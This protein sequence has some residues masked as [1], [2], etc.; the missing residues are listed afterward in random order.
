MTLTVQQPATRPQSEPGRL[1]TLSPARRPRPPTRRAELLRPYGTTSPHQTGPARSSGRPGPGVARH[2]QPPASASPARLRSQRLPGAASRRAE[3]EAVAAASAWTRRGQHI[4]PT[5][6]PRR[7]RAAPLHP[8]NQPSTSTSASST[9]SLWMPARAAGA[10][11]QIHPLVRRARPPR[12][13]GRSSPSSSTAGPLTRGQSVRFS[14][15]AQQQPLQRPPPTAP[16]RGALLRRVG[17]ESSTASLNQISVKR[18]S[19]L[20]ISHTKSRRRRVGT[21]TTATRVARSSRADTSHFTTS[22]QQLSLSHPPCRYQLHE[23]RRRL[24]PRRAVHQAAAAQPAGGASRPRVGPRPARAGSASSLSPCTFST[25]GAGMKMLGKRAPPPRA[26]LSFIVDARGR[27]RAIPGPQLAD[28]LIDTCIVPAS[29]RPSAARARR[30]PA[31]PVVTVDDALPGSNHQQVRRQRRER[32]A[33][34][35]TPARARHRRVTGASPG[36][37]STPT[38][39]A[40]PGTSRSARMLG[41]RRR[42]RFDIAAPSRPRPRPRPRRC[43][44]TSRRPHVLPVGL[45]RLQRLRRR[46]RSGP[47]R[48]WPPVDHRL[49]RPADGAGGRAAVDSVARPGQGRRRRGACSRPRVDRQPQGQGRRVASARARWSTPRQ[50]ARRSRFDLSR[51]QPRGGFSRSPPARAAAR[52]GRPVA[53]GGQIHRG[54]G[55]AAGQRAVAARRPRRAPPA[56][57]DGRRVSPSSST[58]PSGSTQTTSHGLPTLTHSDPPV[59][60]QIPLQR[61]RRAPRRTQRP[62]LL[63]QVVTAGTASGRHSTHDGVPARRSVKL[64]LACHHHPRPVQAVPCRVPDEDEP[65]LSLQPHGRCHRS[66]ARSPPLLEGRR[67]SVSAQ[68]SMLCSMR[69]VTLPARA[70]PRRAPRPGVGTYSARRRSPSTI[71]RAGK[72]APVHQAQCSWAGGARRM[73]L[74]IHHSH[75]DHPRTPSVSSEPIVPVALRTQPDGASPGT[76]VRPANILLEK[77]TTTTAQPAGSTTMTIFQ[78]RV[79]ASAHIRGRPPPRPAACRPSICV[80]VTERLPPTAGPRTP[81]PPRAGRGVE[82]VALLTL[83]EVAHAQRALVQVLAGRR[84][85]RTG[86]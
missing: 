10:A 22:P 21:T 17:I 67:P 83:A 51:L 69:C 32:L 56:F 50:Q 52:R 76:E 24:R 73:H 38:S 29:T 85:C 75:Q 11:R 40:G 44:P 39:P 33:R 84:R 54:P 72:V 28:Q 82:R 63:D 58:S 9:G 25:S 20:R 42:G 3:L 23:V 70:R 12:P 49:R 79:P 45:S 36:R 53:V 30:A 27:R 57:V 41:L 13:A 26:G 46:R 71:P 35:S 7:G 48:C 66:R 6:T 55:P 81:S 43:S 64:D 8:S 80:A 1:G 78:Q 16:A 77:P 19:F 65:D 61:E 74:P 60:H 18:W 47:E 59:L 2:H 14:E 5:S 15:P 37:P 86:S 4:V 62:A 34:T 68:A 31:L